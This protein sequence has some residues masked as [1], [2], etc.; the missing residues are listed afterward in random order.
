MPE[1]MDFVQREDSGRSI[2]GDDP[3]RRNVLLGLIPAKELEQLQP[4]INQVDFTFRQNVR[5][6]GQANEF[7]RLSTR[8]RP[9]DRQ[10]RA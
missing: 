10:H 7:A 1:D 2:A 4:N 6:N 3:M 9:L 5:H 8:L